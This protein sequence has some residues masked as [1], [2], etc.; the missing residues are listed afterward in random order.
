MFFGCHF[1]LLVM[2]ILLYTGHRFTFWSY[3]LSFL[4]R[5]Y[6]KIFDKPAVHLISLQPKPSESYFSHSTSDCLYVN[7]HFEF[8]L[9][10]VEYL[11]CI[12]AGRTIDFEI[13]LFALAGI[14]LL[15]ITL[16]IFLHTHHSTCIF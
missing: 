13:L 12:I 3:F 7:R 15:H 14:V 11:R 8:H 10:L 9:L 1:Q 5:R 2:H 4:A 16:I 6:L